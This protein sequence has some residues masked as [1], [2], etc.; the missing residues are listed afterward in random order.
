MDFG[1]LPTIEGVDFTLPADPPANADVLA[2]Q[3]PRTG[4]AALYVGS[5]GYNQKEWVGKWYP[6]SAREGTFLR[7]YGTQFNTIE[8]NTTHYRLPDEETVARWR[9][10]TPEDFRF[11]PKVL[12]TISHARQLGLYDP[13]LIVQFAKSIRLLG[14]RLGVCFLQL[15]PYF[16]VGELGTLEAFLRVF[17][18]YV[19][20]AIEARHESFFEPG[21]GQEQYFALLR[22][23]NVTAVITDVAGRRD[24]CHM[25]LTTGRTLIRFV[26]NGLHPTDY[27]RVEDWAQRLGDWVA[28]GLRE[29]YFFCHEPGNILSPELAA[30]VAA[31]FGERVPE[32]QVRGPQPLPSP[33]QQASLF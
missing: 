13:A 32:A 30:F 1:K 15:P 8:H 6:A 2:Q 29:A 10:D 16:D 3:P 22:Q 20:L 25:R 11:C 21:D 12:Q 24:V 17:P 19:P 9:H 28:Q 31:T 26:G 27:T 33:G 7:W 4:P 18:I 5:T 23:H 14:D